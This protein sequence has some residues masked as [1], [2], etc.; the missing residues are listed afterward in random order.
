[1]AQKILD[2][3]TAP[4][5]R[6]G[7]PLR[8]AMIKVNDNFTELYGTVTGFAP[9]TPASIKLKYESNEDTNCFTDE[10]K[11]KL[12]GIEEGATTDMTGAEIV[13]AIDLELQGTAWRDGGG[14]LD[15]NAIVNAITLALGDTTWQLGSNSSTMAGNAIVDAIN[16]ELGNTIWQLGGGDGG[17]GMSG[18]DIVAAIDAEL[19]SEVWK[20]GGG[21][22]LTITP[23]SGQSYTVTNADLA[24]GKGVSMT[25]GPGKKIVVPPGLTGTQPLLIVN[26]GTGQTL[27]EAGTGVTLGAADDRTALRV[28]YSTATLIPLGSNTYVLVGDIAP[29][30]AVI[31]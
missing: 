9:E 5:T 26:L 23:V 3:G 15:G 1:M 24:G 2:I 7:D 16:A 6:T 30:T 19:G 4:N 11:A 17:G 31:G 29:P 20:G 18:D 8:D 22:T 27:F 13:E 21:G 25:G 14:E 12:A 28:T 10:E